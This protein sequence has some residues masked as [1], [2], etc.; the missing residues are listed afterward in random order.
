VYY[1]PCHFRF[2]ELDFMNGDSSSNSSFHQ[3][4]W[5]WSMKNV[6]S[7][8]TA[9]FD[10]LVGL[11]VGAV[12][13]AASNSTSRYSTGQAGFPPES[14]NVYALA[15]CTPDLTPLQCRQCLGDLIGD[16][17]RWLTGRFGGRSL[18]VRCN[19]R[20]E[21][22]LFFLGPPKLMLTPLVGSSSSSSSSTTRAAK[23]YHS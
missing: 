4:A 3:A 6:S 22:Y 20:Y 11:L 17:P 2:S 23:G 16:M 19:I 14:I 12:A 8:N 21:S 7:G 15:Q 1:D 5:T 13:D 18:G 10:D 9:A